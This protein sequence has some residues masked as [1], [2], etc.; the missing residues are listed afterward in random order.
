[1]ETKAQVLTIYE[2]GTADISV[3]RRSACAGCDGSSGCCGGQEPSVIQSVTNT[4]GAK[5]G[6]TVLVSLGEKS[7]L[8]L[9]AF[10]FLTPLAVFIAG[11]M[12]K[13]LI[14][15]LILLVPVAFSMFIFNRY[16]RITGAYTPKIISV[17][18]SG[19]EEDPSC[20]DI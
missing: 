13:G 5:P 14:T 11:Y 16:A 1:M 19:E 17:V 6:D 7:F 18:E 9:T 15:G 20:S 4:A 10:L 2:N 3:L 12:I 8:L